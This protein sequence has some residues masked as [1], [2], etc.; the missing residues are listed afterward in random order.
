M[1]HIK[2]CVVHIEINNGIIK[3]H[4]DK[5]KDSI[6]NELIKSGIPQEKIVR[7]NKAKQEYV[8]Y[9]VNKKKIYELNQNYFTTDS[10]LKNIILK[11]NLTSAQLIKLSTI[12]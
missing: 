7:I 12:D 10:N 11:T 6:T 9:V 4:Q 5:L 3:V 1:K 8:E 2:D